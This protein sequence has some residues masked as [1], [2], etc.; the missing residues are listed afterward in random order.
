M[1]IELIDSPS[2]ICHIYIIQFFSSLV[3]VPA[4][5]VPSGEIIIPP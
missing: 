2:S 1:G 5:L 3:I 4:I